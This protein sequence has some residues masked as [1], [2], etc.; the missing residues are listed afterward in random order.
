MSGKA[1]KFTLLRT[2]IFRPL[3]AYNFL[4]ENKRLRLNR[5]YPFGNDNDIKSFEVYTEFLSFTFGSESLK[6]INEHGSSELYDLYE[7]SII[8]M[9]GLYGED[10]Q[11]SVLSLEESMSLYFSVLIMKP[12]TVIETGV[13][14]GISSLFILSALEKNGRGNLYSIDFPEVGMPKLYGKEP[15]RIVDEALRTK[16]TLIYGKSSKELLPLLTKLRFV[17]IFLHDSEHSYPNMK[18]EFSTALKYM[19]KGSLLLS[20]D[21]R[22]N[23]AFLEVCSEFGIDKNN[24]CLLTGKDSDLGYAAINRN[25]KETIRS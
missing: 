2:G 9:K 10:R 5:K 23:G 3:A 1:S 14:D 4:I 22:A 16:W 21:V 6:F 7:K 8:K 20:D 12:E 17:N 25:L 15:G 18:F 19:Q 13:S 11:L 24:I